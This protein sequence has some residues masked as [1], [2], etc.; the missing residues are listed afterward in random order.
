M[1]MQSSP[2]TASLRN[3]KYSNEKLY[4]G[5]IYFEFT[6]SEAHLSIACSFEKL[7]KIVYS[8]TVN[9]KIRTTYYSTVPLIFL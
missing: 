7:W 2:S 1:H 5:L 6:L 3:K 9:L 4:L 8:T